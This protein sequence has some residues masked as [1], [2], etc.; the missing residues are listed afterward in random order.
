[1]ARLTLSLA[2]L[3]GAAAFVLQQPPKLQTP[4]RKG[5]ALQAVDSLVVEPI[6]KVGGVVRLQGSK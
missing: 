2:A 6:A 5:T 1:M 4:L 3:A